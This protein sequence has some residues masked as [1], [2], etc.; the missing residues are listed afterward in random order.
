M[1]KRLGRLKLQLIHFQEAILLVTVLVLALGDM[2]L[3]TELATR[4][5]A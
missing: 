5:E 2:F 1:V 3:L 4:E